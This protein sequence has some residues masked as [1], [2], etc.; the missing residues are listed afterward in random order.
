MQL[1]ERLDPLTGLEQPRVERAVLGQSDHL[2]GVLVELDG[3]H[4]VAVRHGPIEH[5][6]LDLHHLQRVLEG[7]QESVGRLV[8]A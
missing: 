6:G 2:V 7:D 5:L 4:R 3:D 1:A 8:K